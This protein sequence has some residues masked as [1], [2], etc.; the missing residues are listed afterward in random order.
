MAILTVLNLPIQEF[1]YL[2]ISLNHLQFPL[3]MF[4]SSHLIRF[5]SPWSGLFYSFWCTFKGECCCGFGFVF[6]KL[7]LSDISLLIVEKCNRFLYVN[8]VSCYLDE[9]VSSN[10]FGWSLLR[11]SV[12][13]CLLHIMIILP[14]FLPIWISRIS[15]RCCCLIAVARTSNAMLNRSGDRI[16]WQSRG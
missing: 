14:H 16:S 6:L 13:S 7:S 9:F 1:V 8:F 3:S 10:V 15:F 2:F 5:S 11:F 4:Y 12:V